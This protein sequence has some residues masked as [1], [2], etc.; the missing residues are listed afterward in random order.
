MNWRK[1]GELFFFLCVF[2]YNQLLHIFYFILF[3]LKKIS[4]VSFHHNFFFLLLFLF[5][6]IFLLA[7][8]FFFYSITLLFRMKKKKK[9]KCQK[10]LPWKIKIKNWKN[11]KIENKNWYKKMKWYSRDKINSLLRGWFFLWAFI[12]MGNQ[13]YKPI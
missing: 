6:K 12:F 8:P 13:R 10:F 9:S 1:W 2:L 3:Y 4:K 5:R 11:S 7:F